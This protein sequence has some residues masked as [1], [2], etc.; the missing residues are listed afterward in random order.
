MEKIIFHPL[1][2]ALCCVRIHG[3]EKLRIGLGMS[4]Y[5]PSEVKG[6]SESFI[7]NENNN[8]AQMECL[9]LKYNYSQVI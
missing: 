6:V 4:E 8:M 2:C 1:L 5:L 9:R 7:A 3:N